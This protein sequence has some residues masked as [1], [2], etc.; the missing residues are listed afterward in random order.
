MLFFIPQPEKKQLY[1]SKNAPC[2]GVRRGTVAHLTQVQIEMLHRPK[3]RAEFFKM[4]RKHKGGKGHPPDLNP[5]M[6]YVLHSLHFTSCFTVGRK[7]YRERPI[8]DISLVCLSPDSAALNRCIVGNQTIACGSA[9][10]Q[11]V[12]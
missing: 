1:E 10:S 8:Y 3:P 11:A 7:Q 4:T 2:L 9:K 6:G 5:T 12:N